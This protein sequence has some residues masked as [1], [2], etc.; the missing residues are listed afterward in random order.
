MIQ[1]S[2]ERLCLYAL[3]LPHLHMLS[4]ARIDLESALDL[5][6]GNLKVG[7]D[8]SFLDMFQLALDEFVIPAVSKCNETTYAWFTHWLIVDKQQQVTVG[9]IGAS[10]WPDNTGSTMIGYFIDKQQE[11]RGFATEAV[12][13]LVY[14][15]QSNPTL[16]SIYA[17]TP[18][19]N[20]ASQKVLQKSGFMLEGPIDEGLRWRLM[21][22]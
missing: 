14:W 16:I 19:D 9:G 15:M 12:Q 2:S 8:S 1:I 21:L 10:G 3:T 17:D 20:I 18:E 11:G 6:P 5:R 13:S 22:Q 4:K 7:N